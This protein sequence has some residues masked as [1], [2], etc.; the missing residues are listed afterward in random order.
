[1]WWRLSIGVRHDVGGGRRVIVAH[2]G[3]RGGIV[4]VLAFVRMVVALRARIAESDRERREWL[5]EREQ[6]I[7]TMPKSKKRKAYRTKR[8]VVVRPARR[9]HGPAAPSGAQVNAVPAAA[10]SVAISADDLHAALLKLGGVAG[11]GIC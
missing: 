2:F 4:L 8:T 5:V 1:M 11:A 7:R 6:T 10:H 9:P 3:D